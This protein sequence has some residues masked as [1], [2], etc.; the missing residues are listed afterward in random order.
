VLNNDSRRRYTLPLRDQASERFGAIYGYPLLSVLVVWRNP[1]SS[2]WKGRE[3]N[4]EDLCLLA[5]VGLL[6]PAT[7]CTRPD[8]QRGGTQHKGVQI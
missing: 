6:L 4:E 3:E 1:P 2:G 8:L 5:A 7:A